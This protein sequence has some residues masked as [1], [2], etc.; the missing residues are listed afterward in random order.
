MGKTRCLLG[1]RHALIVHLERADHAFDV[2]GVYELRA[3]GVALGKKGVQ[4]LVA[5]ALMQLEVGGSAFVFQ[6]ALGKLHDVEGGP[7]VETG[8]PT[9]NR[10]PAVLQQA[11]DVR[12]GIALIEGCGIRLVGLDEVDEA[13]GDEPL[14][15]GR[16]CGA[17]IHPAVHLHGVGGE[18]LGPQGERDAIRHGAL[19]H[20]G[21]AGDGE[22]GN[23]RGSPRELPERY[24]VRAVSTRTSSILP[25]S[26]R[27]SMPA[28]TGQ[29]TVWFQGLL[30]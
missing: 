30:P 5:Q 29:W 20:R 6:L 1:I 7:E 25:M 4:P 26:G 15:L 11:I 23:H 13:Q 28:G 21:G 14:G 18:H 22:N 12:S 24:H 17:D 10:N 8:S 2:V 27:A 3:S 19:P 16:L 9:Y